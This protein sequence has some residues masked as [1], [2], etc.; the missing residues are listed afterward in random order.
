MRVIFKLHGLPI[1]KPVNSKGLY[2][3]EPK[4]MKNITNRAVT[5]GA[6]TWNDC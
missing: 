4:D 5:P 2:V 6:A 1:L 3:G